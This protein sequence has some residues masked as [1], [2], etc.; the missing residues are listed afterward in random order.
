[1]L[2]KVFILMLIPYKRA[3]GCFAA[4]GFFQ[5]EENSIDVSHVNWA[6]R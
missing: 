1:M 4:S 5:V 2:L 3:G 6:M